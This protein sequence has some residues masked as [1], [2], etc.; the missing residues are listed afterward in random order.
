L[1]LGGELKKDYIFKLYC[2]ETLKIWDIKFSDL[3]EKGKD[4]LILYSFMFS[5]EDN[6]PC[7]M[8]NSLM[9]SLNG[10]AKHVKQR[11]NFYAIGKADPEKLNNWRNA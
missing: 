3:F 11:V 1:P 4:T 9:A 7:P 6:A 8:C 5:P 10:A 2:D